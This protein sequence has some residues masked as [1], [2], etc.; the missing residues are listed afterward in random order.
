MGFSDATIS[1]G[2][3]TVFGFLAFFTPVIVSMTQI[4]LGGDS[5]GTGMDIAR[6]PSNVL[7]SS[8]L[9]F[10]EHTLEWKRR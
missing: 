9:A 3:T 8:I 2:A 10:G 5:C 7:V 6:M 1:I 4:W